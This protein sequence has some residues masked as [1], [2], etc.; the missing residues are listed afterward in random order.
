M[1]WI[2]ELN[3]GKLPKDTDGAKYVARY[4]T[5]PKYCLL[6]LRN[7]LFVPNVTLFSDKSECRYPDAQFKWLL[8]DGN[9]KEANGQEFMDRLTQVN[10][11]S[12]KYFASCWYN[13][14]DGSP[15]ETMWSAY[16]EDG[17]FVVFEKEKLISAIL[18]NSYRP[19]NRDQ[20][21]KVVPCGYGPVKYYGHVEFADWLA[22]HDVLP[23]PAFAK[24]RAF[25]PENEFRIVFDKSD[26]EN[27]IQVGLTPPDIGFG[28]YFEDNIEEY[29]LVRIVYK[30]KQIKT[31]IH[32]I[33]DTLAQN[34][35][36][37]LPIEIDSDIAAAY[38]IKDIKNRGW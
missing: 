21:Q 38:G 26:F 6:I 15:N 24:R 3:I 7:I 16:A 17:V 11:E 29:G 9:H 10:Q 37:T 22:A 23:H 27:N 28:L 20:K 30:S 35:N 8:S 32:A 25:H 12:E 2:S 14:E 4:L 34:S 33:R 1:D 18:N 36:R 13:S 5:L 19:Y 31:A